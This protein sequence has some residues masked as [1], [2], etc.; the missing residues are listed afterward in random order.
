M[1]NLVIDDN[2][3]G[4]CTDMIMM[5]MIMEMHGGGRERIDQ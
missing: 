4:I 3:N 5:F 1:I 2:D